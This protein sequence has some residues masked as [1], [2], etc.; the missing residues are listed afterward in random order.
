MVT[1]QN[2]SKRLLEVLAS[3][4]SIESLREHRELAR[5]SM[6]TLMLTI[7]LQCSPMLTLGC[8]NGD[9]RERE[10]ESM[11]TSE[12]LENLGGKGGGTE[13]DLKITEDFYL[14]YTFINTIRKN[15]I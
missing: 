11:N 2:G 5:A 3:I 13:G 12:H 8:S 7:V 15:L 1:H 10:R 4:A 9:G 14:G 6:R